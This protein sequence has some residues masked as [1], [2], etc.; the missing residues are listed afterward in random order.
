MA[1]RAGTVALLLGRGKSHSRIH[2]AA[3]RVCADQSPSNPL[4]R[5]AQNFS[6]RFPPNS[7]PTQNIRRTPR[8]HALG[9][10][11][12]LAAPEFPLADLPIPSPSFPALPPPFPHLRA[13]RDPQ[14]N[15]NPSVR[16]RRIPLSQ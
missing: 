15:S 11:T 8:P 12:F 5:F 3:I 13:Q 9:I 4:R 14:E 2:T 16:T 6:S 10:H 1:N 7:R